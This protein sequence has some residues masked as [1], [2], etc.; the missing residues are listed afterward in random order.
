MI[1]DDVVGG[2]L[3]PPSEKIV[4]G[5][6]GGVGGPLHLRTRDEEKP[7]FSKKPGFWKKKPGF[8]KKPGFWNRP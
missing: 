7:G 5:V 1:A 3:E 2:E 8:S 4:V 6:L